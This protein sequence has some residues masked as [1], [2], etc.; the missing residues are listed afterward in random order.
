MKKTIYLL[1]MA[2]LCL[3]FKVT[4]QQFAELS[5]QV[6][7][8]S[9]KPL[10][11]ATV[12]IKSG[13]IIATTDNNGNF[14]I[15]TSANSGTLAISYLGYQTKEVA[16]DIT[17]TKL[18]KVI[19]QESESALNEV[20]IV[21]TGYQNIS[22]E[23]ATGSFTTIN[24]ELLNRAVSPDLLSR[25]KGITNGLLVDQSVGGFNIRGRS[26]IFS[27]TYPLIVVD[28]FPFE[29]D[30]NSINPNDVENVTV[31]K[32]AAAASIWGVR[33]GNGVL[34]ITTKKGKLNEK[35]SINF[36]G[37]L[38][39]G[40]QPD[41]YYQPQMSP[42]DFI[43][44]EKFL[45]EKGVNSFLPSYEVISPVTVELEKAKLNPS[46]T[47]QANIEI[48]KLRKLDARNHLDKYFLRKSIRQQYNVGVSGGGSN[49]AFL[50][51]AGYD[52]NQPNEIASSDSR[53]S[54]KGNNIYHFFNNR[55]KLS[56][57]INFIKT[58]NRNNNAY[59][60]LPYLPYEQVA[61]LN[62]N[63]IA[64]LVRS[65]LREVYTD[66]AGTGR[67][68]DWKYRPLEEL[69]NE[70]SSSYTNTN[71][72][73]LLLGA[74]YKILDP[75]SLSLNYQ[76]FNSNRKTE[77]SYSQ[78]SFYTRNLI[79]RLSQINSVTGQVSRP[80][81]LGD[82]YSPSFMNNQGN[83]GRIQLDFNK[84]LATKH[85]LNAIGGYEIRDNQTTTNSN[86]L[87]GYY[88]EIASSALINPVQQYPWYYG[89]N[90]STIGKTSFQSVSIDRYIS[91]YAN[92]S[93][94][95]D[96]KYILSGSYRKDKSNLFGVNANQKGVPLWSAGLLWNIH[97]ESFFHVNWLSIL[98]IKGTYGYNGNV[99][100]SISAYLT[101]QSLGINPHYGANYYGII[102]PPND[103]LRWERVKNINLGID[104]SSENSRLS[105]SIEYYTKKGIDLI[106]TSPIAP[107]SGV[108]IYTGNSADTRTKGIDIQLNS[109]NLNGRFKWLSTVILNKAKDKVST[110]K[111][112]PGTNS[113]IMGAGINP[114]IGYPIRSIFAYK[115]EG[116]DSSGEP[117]GRLNGIIS[118]DY[119][120]IL[121]QKDPL[122]LDFYG[123]AT[124]IFFGSLRNTFS[125]KNI[126][127]SFNIS[128]KF[129]Y[130]FRRNSYF[131]YTSNHSDYT[132]RW[133][134]P[135]DE[136]QSNVPALIYPF[137]AVRSSFYQYSSVLIEKGDHIRLQDV[138]LNYLIKK[139]KNGGFPYANLNIYCY[140]T[141]LWILWRANKHG[142]DPDLAGLSTGYP[143]PK[144]IAFGLKTNF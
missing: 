101:A 112:N 114:I 8:A 93:Y 20:S 1:V 65:G 38:T 37:N 45:F 19:L 39:L 134:K 57:D 51:S 105:G 76:L 91:Y 13:N 132:K 107:Q 9:G 120:S 52:K 72:F 83:Y 128:Y 66:T 141:N 69:R 127:L 56:T 139:A 32:D 70:N 90:S 21:S 138:Q 119:T 26:T 30:I 47:D 33:A 6:T 80:I 58:T 4:A 96:G 49:H 137:S 82:I 64:T 11:G 63:P 104:F 92:A 86:T 53:L 59:T 116:L 87:Y 61:D 124:P 54:L 12:K 110:Y 85:E 140:A 50:F 14:K 28:N 18:I 144:T 108:S 109:V 142:L 95:Y 94:T 89:F 99:N 126:E 123:S 62:G 100:Q 77:Q 75:L 42:S 84:V 55:L 67:L 133:Q 106:G 44:V 117:Q 16:F 34:V 24:N 15:N 10:A 125:Y 74:T 136:L 36:N 22:K 29:G 68:L 40:D 25:L 27:Q 115:W 43:D 7:S 98:R 48:D 81:P 121:N 2:V 111:A 73:R 113:T 88:P 79:N 118:K 17:N 131:D 129:D 102:N 31:L 97:K 103:D 130:Y 71:D 135:G 60:Y 23:R 41:L 46:Y 35:P 143:S 122:A 3:N 5:G 78:H